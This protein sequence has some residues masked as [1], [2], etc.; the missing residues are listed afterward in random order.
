MGTG[1]HKGMDPE[2]SKLLETGNFYFDATC[3]LLLIA[4]KTN[5]ILRSRHPNYN[6]RLIFMNF[7]LDYTTYFKQL[8]NAEESVFTREKDKNGFGTR[9]IDEFNKIIANKEVLECSPW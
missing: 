8:I 3:L 6:D 2:I 9:I 1:K 7:S 4:K 5:L